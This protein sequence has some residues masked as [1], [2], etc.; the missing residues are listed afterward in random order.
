M[1]GNNT[2]NINVIANK[3]NTENV[4]W[5]KRFYDKLCPQKFSSSLDFTQPSNQL[6]YL[7]YYDSSDIKFNDVMKII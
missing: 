1:F 6:M 4:A 5:G 7:R 2:I 3:A